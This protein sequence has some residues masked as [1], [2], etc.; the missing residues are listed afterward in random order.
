MEAKDANQQDAS[1]DAARKTEAT[2]NETLA[3]LEATENVKP[4]SDSATPDAPA[5]QPASP[6]PDPDQSADDRASEPM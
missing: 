6:A 3:D 5:A 4:K 2:S 1:A